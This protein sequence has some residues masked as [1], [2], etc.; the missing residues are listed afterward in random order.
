VDKAGGYAHLEKY[1]FAVGMRTTATPDNK[2]FEVAAD[3]STYFYGPVYDAEGNSIVGGT[4]EWRDLPINTTNITENAAMYAKDGSVVNIQG[5]V[6]LKARLETDKTVVVAT[7]PEGFRPR[8][9]SYFP[10]MMGGLVFRVNVNADGTL[11]VS[12]FSSSSI[13]NTYALPLMCNYMAGN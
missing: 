1:G 4:P 3:Y 7:I 2:K 6:K 10:N 12:N 8:V 13:S 9:T 11:S 5:T